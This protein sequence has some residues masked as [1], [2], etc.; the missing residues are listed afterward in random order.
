MPYRISFST[1]PKTIHRLLQ[2]C[3]CEGRSLPV[4]LPE[5]LASTGGHTRRESR[6]LARK[7]CGSSPGI[8]CLF[9]PLHRKLLR[10]ALRTEDVQTF[11]LDIIGAAPTRYRRLARLKRGFA[12]LRQSLGQ[13]GHPGNTRMDDVNRTLHGQ[14]A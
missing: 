14:G 8:A 2:R 11:G 10:Q 6:E 9:S 1:T 7:R 5:G 3:D 12:C 4:M 13:F